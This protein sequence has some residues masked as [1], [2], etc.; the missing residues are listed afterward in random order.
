VHFST[1]YVFGGTATHPYSEDAAFDPKTAYGRSKAAGET[2]VLELNPGRSHIIRTAFLYGEHGVNF[3]ATML[4]LATER[5]TL[6]VVSD[7]IGQPTWTADLAAQTIALLDTGIPSG[8]WHGTNSGQAS[9]FDFAQ[10]IFGEAG[11]DAARVSP[12]SSEQFVRPAPR[13]AYSVLGHDHWAAAGI[14]PMRPW[15]EA[16]SAAFASG[17]LG[18]S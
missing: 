10:A 8:T 1:D 5:E 2:L 11:L 17:A 3:A 14:P 15:R 4:R 18:A 7:Q 9:W 16:L 6:T 12:V 13:P